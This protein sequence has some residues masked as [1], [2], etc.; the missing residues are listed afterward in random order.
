MAFFTQQAAAI[1][2]AVQKQIADGTYVA[3]PTTTTITKRTPRTKLGSAVQNIGTKIVDTTKNIVDAAK[4]TLKNPA[5]APLVVL[6]P[7]MKSALQKKGIK[8]KSDSVEDLAEAFHTAIVKKQPYKANYSYEVNNL[9]P[10]LVTT[11]VTA[12]I[13][14]IKNLKK[15]KEDGI[16]LTNEEQIILNEA[17]KVAATVTDYAKDEAKFQVGDFLSKNWVFI[18]AGLVLVGY[19]VMRK[20]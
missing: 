1:N 15:K 2:T 14:F 18:V 13:D 5:F 4:E 20:K 8:Y 9:D 11:I 10:F 12:I 19:F 16:A 7:V 6:K 3:P 17:E